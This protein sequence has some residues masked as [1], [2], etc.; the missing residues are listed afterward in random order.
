MDSRRT[1]KAF[2]W[3]NPKVRFDIESKPEVRKLLAD[4][5]DI[6]LG[7]EKDWNLN[8]ITVRESALTPEILSEMDSALGKESYSTEKQ[9]RLIHALGKSYYDLIRLRTLKLVDAPDVV[10]YPKNEAQIIQALQ[11]AEKHDMAVVPFAGGTSVVGGVEAYRKTKPYLASLD[12]T[13][14]NKILDLDKESHIV[15]VEAGIYGPELENY[16]NQRGYTLGHFPQSFEFT[17][18]GGWIAARSSGQNSLY[19]GNIAKIAVHLK[20]ITPSGI[21]E[22]SKVPSMATGPDIKHLLIGSEG[23]FGVLYCC[24]LKIHPL[25]EEKKYFAYL[26]RSF[27][28]ASKVSQQILQ[29]GYQPAM[30]RVS[31]ED[32]TESML[33]LLGSSDKWH[34]RALSKGLKTLLKLKRFSK[35]SLM[36]IGLEGTRTSNDYQ[37]LNINNVIHCVPA[38]YL[39]THAGKKWLK[40]RFQTPYLRDPFM[41]SGLMVD[42]LETATTW[43]NLLPLYRAV[44]TALHEVF[45][46]QRV[47]AEVYTHISHLYETGASLYFSII[48][49]QLSNPESQWRE[50]KKAVGKTIVDHGGVISHH[51]GIGL[52]HKDFLNASETELAVLRSLKNTLDPKAIMNPGKLID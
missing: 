25:P 26:F 33:T 22:T 31:D 45:H 18:A 3:G 27:E 48:A 42:T 28:D 1:M 5:F 8:D 43:K 23:I 6:T 50:M 29:N 17:T 19:Y 21:I 30:I 47:S 15:T 34:K 10:L 37:R 11:L 9:D 13:P 46:Q 16:L 32:E 49:K 2:G 14:L 24:S 38:F 52:D 35:P 4:K 44:K 20:M 41:D 40:E 7:N 51:H 36:L 39:G 12:V